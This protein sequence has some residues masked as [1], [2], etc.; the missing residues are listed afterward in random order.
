M[1]YGS[2]GGRYRNALNIGSDLCPQSSVRSGGTEPSRY[3]H[4]RQAQVRVAAGRYPGPG[5]YDSGRRGGVV[6]CRKGSAVNGTFLAGYLAENPGNVGKLERGLTRPNLNSPALSSSYMPGRA[7]AAR[8][9]QTG[10]LFELRS[11]SKPS[12][13]CHSGRLFSCQARGVLV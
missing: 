5:P 9:G 8:R 6:V 2:A 4:H 11:D 7:M 10:S 13:K 1:A 12:V 3:P